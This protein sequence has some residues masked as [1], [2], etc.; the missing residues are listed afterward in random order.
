MSPALGTLAGTLLAITFAATAVVAPVRAVYVLAIVGGLQLFQ[1][2]VVSGH[3]IA[4]GLFPIEIMASVCLGLVALD[5]LGRRPASTP[6]EIDRP[7]TWLLAVAT[8]SFVV[9][10]FV[11]DAAVN[12]AHLKPLVSIGQLLLMAWPFAVYRFVARHVV[13]EATVRRLLVTLTVLGVPGV[14][15]PFAGDELRTWLRWS[16]Y[17]GL[18]MAPFCFAQIFFVR[19]TVA[20]L[21]LAGLAVT[22]AINGLFIGKAFLYGYV[23]VFVWV[24]SVIRVPRLALAGLIVGAGL[25]LSIAVPL[26]G[27]IL[28]GV[29]QRLVSLEERQGSWGGQS[30]RVQLAVDTVQIWSRHP[31]FGVG[32][33]NNWP[34][35]NRYSVIDTPHNQYLNV[36]LETGLAGLIAFLA[37]LLGC[38]RVGWRL[39]RSARSPLVEMFAL[40][41]LGYFSAMAAG[42]LTGDFMLHSIR[43][44]GLELLTGFYLQ[45]VML[46]LLVALERLEASAE[47]GHAEE[48]A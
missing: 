46:G 25:Y 27:T 17:F 30:G 23:A 3:R 31:V 28:P 6:G 4:Q 37:L 33:G 8:I 20:R 14:L 22:P 16:V 2:F 11:A 35:M 39:Y 24:I 44:G 29:L 21:A 47:L 9:N 18:A 38:L 26:R 7:F 12:Q 10:L 48:A 34:Y 43:N 5:A 36:L 40:G 15:V 41:W 42:G 32:P 19:S 1:A 45:W 13:S